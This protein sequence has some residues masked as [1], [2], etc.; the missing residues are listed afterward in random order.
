MHFTYKLIN[1]EFILPY[2]HPFE[3]LFP[4]LRDRFRFYC[5]KYHTLSS[6]FVALLF[7]PLEIIHHTL[8]TS[9][10]PKKVQ[11]LNIYSS[12]YSHHPSGTPSVP[13]IALTQHRPL[14]RY[15]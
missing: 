2:Y 12:F 14:E 10:E 8:S 11:K 1:L 13:G 7:R 3:T 5:T 9:E 6:N 4:N 15:L